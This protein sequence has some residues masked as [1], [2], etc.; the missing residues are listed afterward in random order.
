MTPRDTGTDARTTQ[1]VQVRAEGQVDE[2][3]LDYV[4]TKVNAVF[5]RPGLPA[6]T[7]EV[8][9]AK[10]TAHHVEQ[11]WSAAAEIRVGS[12]LLVVHADEASAHEVADRLQDRLRGRL[13]RLADRWATA[14]RSAA[15]PPW[16]GGPADARQG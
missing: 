3:T 15:P 10:A 5:D 12:E 9:I 6:V 14:R 13:D 1:A 11:P 4:R 2:A 8:R 7:G 16:R